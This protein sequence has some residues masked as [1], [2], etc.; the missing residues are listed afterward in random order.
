MAFNIEMVKVREVLQARLDAGDSARGIARRANLGPDAVRDILRGKSA[1]AKIDTLTAIAKAIGSDLSV[2]TE[3]TVQEALSGVNFENNAL[4]NIVSW[5]KNVPV[6]GTAMGGA[7]E[8]GSVASDMQVEQTILGLS[9]VIDMVRRPPA[10]SENR[11]LYAVYVVGSSMEPRHEAGDLIYVDPKRPP[12][13]GDDVVIQLR[14]PVGH[15]GEE[16][17]I[18]GLIKRLV[19]RNATTVELEQYN[20][21]LR[22]R[23]GF[24]HIAAM[25]RVVRYGEVMGQ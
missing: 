25:H 1:H 16:Q 20:P 3:G 15:D 8:L 9:E 11:K 14:A 12:A 2:F 17:V 21:G 24:E 22:F 10:F 19:R 13:I 18:C 6:L 23:L 5:P 4:P 7:L